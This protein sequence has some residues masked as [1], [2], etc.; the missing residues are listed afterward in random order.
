MSYMDK[1]TV[2]AS[3]AIALAVLLAVVAFDWSS[4]AAAETASAPAAPQQKARVLIV[5]GVD[6][7][8]H[9]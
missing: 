2:A 5:T 7:P 9:L 1:G 6:Y 8:G 3:G 4:A